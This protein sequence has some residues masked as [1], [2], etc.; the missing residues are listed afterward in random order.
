MREN[1]AR[2]PAAAECTNI[3]NQMED[4]LRKCNT[5]ATPVSACYDVK[6][7]YCFIWP[8]ELFCLTSGIGGGGQVC[9]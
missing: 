2:I 6:T 7:K 5:M 3:K 8:R 4:L 1:C 9:F